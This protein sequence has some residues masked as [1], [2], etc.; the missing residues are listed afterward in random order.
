METINN[1]TLREC[2][3]EV[4]YPDTLITDKSVEHLLNLKGV[5]AE[6]LKT[7]METGKVTKF[8][9]IEGIDR[10]FLRDNLKMKD[11]AIIMA[12]GMLLENPKYN[13]MLLKRKAEALN[14]G[15]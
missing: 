7:W 14:S 12:Y 1:M 4:G 3:L 2:L 6:M 8:E 9:A 13:A 10:N 15:K 11:P 5:A